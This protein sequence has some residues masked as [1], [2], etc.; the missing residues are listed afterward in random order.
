M[1]QSKWRNFIVGAMLHEGVRQEG[2]KYI[3]SISDLTFDL[4][5]DTFPT[6]YQNLTGADTSRPMY[7]DAVYLPKGDGS[8][9][10]I[11]D[12]IALDDY[13]DYIMSRV[14]NVDII[15]DPTTNKA[16]I[17]DPKYKEREAR[18]GKDIMSYYDD[19]G[20]YQGD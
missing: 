1:N 13:K 14:G 10:G 17:E 19:T 18:I 6:K 9:K 20:R 7:R 4:L 3:V 8:S 2:D 5:K 11:I 12:T 16:T 15:L